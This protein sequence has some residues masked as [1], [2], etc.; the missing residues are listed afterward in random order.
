MMQASGEYGRRG[1]VYSTQG[2]GP[3]V[4]AHWHKNRDEGL[5]LR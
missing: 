4:T 5:V 2:C 3:T 1:Q